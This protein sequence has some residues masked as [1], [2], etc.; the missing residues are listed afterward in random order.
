M[1]ERHHYEPKTNGNLAPGDASVLTYSNNKGYGRVS[2]GLTILCVFVACTS[3]FLYH[4]RSGGD[5]P[6][7]DT[8]GDCAHNQNTRENGKSWLKSQEGNE[9]IHQSEYFRAVFSL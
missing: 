3:L 1:R 6:C 7:S 2:K 8:E 4:T 9:S 5:L